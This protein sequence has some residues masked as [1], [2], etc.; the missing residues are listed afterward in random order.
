MTGAPSVPARWPGGRGYGSG[1]SSV[2]QSRGREQRS[3]AVA[4]FRAGLEELETSLAP[5][6][7]TARCPGWT[8]PAPR[9][10]TQLR[11]SS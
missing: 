3:A 7:G 10:K 11:A 2:A 9:G 6:A 8:D 5:S 1:H 4:W